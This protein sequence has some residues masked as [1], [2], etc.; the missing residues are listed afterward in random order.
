M[1]NK[2]NPQFGEQFMKAV[3]KASLNALFAI[4]VRSEEN[5]NKFI[6][7]FTENLDKSFID[8]GIVPTEPAQPQIEK[9]EGV[10]AT[11]KLVESPTTKD[12]TKDD[13]T[14][15][16]DKF[17]LPLVKNL[18][19]D[20]R[21]I[22]ILEKTKIHSIEELELEMGKRSLTEIVGITEQDEKDIREALKTWNS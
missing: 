4:G 16:K 19:I 5:I 6:I 9:S 13:V 12:T 22:D 1:N 10:E 11:P 20:I 3:T 7:A 15:A 2:G 18:G 14:V 8:L 17:G 21:L